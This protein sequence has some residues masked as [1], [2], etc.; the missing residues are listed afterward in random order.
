TR[1]LG[2]RDEY[3]RRAEA[4]V[5][6][7]PGETWA[8]E[9]LNNLATHYILVDDDAAAD[10]IFQRLAKLFPAGRHAPRAAWKVGW[11]AYRQGRHADTAAIF[12]SASSAFPRSNYRPSWIY[13]AARSRDQLGDTRLANRL[14]GILVADYL[15]SYY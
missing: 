11:F 13:W 8:E 14:Y 9:T 6:E 7:F 2:E 1:E 4:L 10:R 15:N 5:S 12:E 3:V